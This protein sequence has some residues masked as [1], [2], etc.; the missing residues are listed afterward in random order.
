VKSRA[1]WYQ[2]DD[3]HEIKHLLEPTDES[4]V[5]A[6]KKRKKE[7]QT[8]KIINDS[9]GQPLVDCRSKIPQDVF[10]FVKSQYGYDRST[11]SER[12]N[13][14]AITTALRELMQIKS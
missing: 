10:D 3:Y 9:R 13:N 11:G 6:T 2:V 7:T 8:V 1:S 4:V 5:Q 14:A 12:T